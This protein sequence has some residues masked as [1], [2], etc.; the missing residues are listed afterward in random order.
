MKKLLCISVI[1]VFLVTLR[2]VEGKATRRQLP[3]MLMFMR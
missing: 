3:Q 1:I 2:R